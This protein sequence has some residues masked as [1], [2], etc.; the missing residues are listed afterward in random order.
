MFG[1]TGPLRAVSCHCRIL[2]DK[3][4]LL[5]PSCS[6]CWCYVRSWRERCTVLRL[7]TL[8]PTKMTEVMT[9]AET[10]T[11][12]ATI[13]DLWAQMGQMQKSVATVVRQSLQIAR[14]S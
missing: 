12:V 6:L 1:S 9:T 8:A 13:K 7:K 5:T 2:L 10:E 11:V 4:V 3:R 14:S